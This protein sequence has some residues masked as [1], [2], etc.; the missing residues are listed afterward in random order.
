MGQ[1]YDVVDADAHVL[2]PIDAWEKYID[3]KFRGQA[4]HMIYTD[5]G[6]EIYWFSDDFSLGSR[7]RT[8]GGCGS[9]GA[10]EG[11]V[12]NDIKYVEGRKGGFDPHARIPDLDKE[13]VDAAFLYPT[14]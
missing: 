3:P 12:S 9:I 4:P 1:R 2:E 14:L 8:I 11:E 6:G 7:G 13:G 5:D 10:R